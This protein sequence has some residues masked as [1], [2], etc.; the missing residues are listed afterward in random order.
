M[1]SADAIV[2]WGDFLHSRDFVVQT[3]GVLEKIGAVPTHHDGVQSVL[4]AVYLDGENRDIARKT[5]LFGG[6]IL[7]N[8]ANDYLESEYVSALKGLLLD[9]SGV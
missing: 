9:A 3:A 7:F 1:R 5:I 8:T 6:T 2:Y 4:K